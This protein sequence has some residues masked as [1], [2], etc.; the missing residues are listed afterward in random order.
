VIV[1][2][3]MLDI[4]LD[5]SR[6]ATNGRT[7][8]D[9]LMD[10]KIEVD[11]GVGFSHVMDAEVNGMATEQAAYALASL[12]RALAGERPLFDMSDVERSAYPFNKPDDNNNNDNNEDSGNDNDNHNDNNNDNIGNNN[13]ND[14]TID[15]R[16]PITDNIQ[17]QTPSMAV[18]SINAARVAAIKDRTYKG[19][20]ITPAVKVTLGSSTL[21]SGTDYT[22]AYKSNATVGKA[23]VTIKGVGVYTGT[24]T[25]T[26]KILPAKATFKRAKT[27]KRQV[28]LKWTPAKGIGKQQ[29]QYRV[30]G[31]KKWRTV[32][33]SAKVSSKIVKKL[34]SGKTYQFRI[35]G[36][37]V[38][39]GKGYYALWSAIKSA[40]VKKV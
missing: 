5:D 36:Y 20:A 27:G 15:N 26:F 39:D 25:A 16:G 10:F 2:L 1:A 17:R 13:D 9:A 24:L 30:K 23:T 4:A 34:K 8:Y 29:L 40:K 37:K 6:F 22:V 19:K 21:R 11:G 14:N 31:A 3:N 12:S 35:R 38:V 18:Q 28:A 33:L 32:T 7:A